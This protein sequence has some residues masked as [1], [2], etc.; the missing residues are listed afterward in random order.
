MAALITPEVTSEAFW[1]VANGD[2]DLDATPISYER[3]IDWLLDVQQSTDDQ[4][5]RALVA[6]VLRDV[7]ALGPINGDRELE[8]VVLGALASVEVAFEVAA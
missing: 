4:Q 3:C 5:L 2:E 7:Q 8:S 1:A 6:D